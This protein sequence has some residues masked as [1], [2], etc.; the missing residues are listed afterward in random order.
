MTK[1]EIKALVAAKIAGQGT[2]VDAGGA[3]PTILSEIIELI[4]SGTLTPLIVTGGFDDMNLFI[5][6]EGQPTFEQ[7]MAAFRAGTPVILTGETL[8]VLVTACEDSQ[9]LIG[10]TGTTPGE[11]PGVIGWSAV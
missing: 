7:A 2:M 1:N 6:D 11:A 5:P 10:S 8:Q 3:L 4:P 9:M